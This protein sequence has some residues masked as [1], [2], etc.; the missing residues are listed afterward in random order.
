MS[1]EAKA[2]SMAYSNATK[3]IVMCLQELTGEEFTTARMGPKDRFLDALDALRKEFEQRVEAK[4]DLMG[5]GEI[6]GPLKEATNEAEVQRLIESAMG[7]SLDDFTPNQIFNAFLATAIEEGQEDETIDLPATDFL[8]KVISKLFQSTN[9]QGR[10]NVGSNRHWPRLW[11]WLS[12]YSERTD[13]G[14]GIGVKILNASRTGPV[15][16]FPAEPASLIVRI[17]RNWL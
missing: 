6:V 13:F 16:R 8:R 2:A 9:T 15:A 17:D 14:D 10:V 12:E 5:L 7:K 11:Q 1:R 3:A 4:A